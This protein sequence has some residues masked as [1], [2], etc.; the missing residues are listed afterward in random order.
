MAKLSGILR[1]RNDL[2]WI[3]ISKMCI[4][5]RWK[6]TNALSEISKRNAE[7][8]ARQHHHGAENCARGA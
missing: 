4:R 8:S 1:A 7:Y 3:H 5:S 2:G 6:K